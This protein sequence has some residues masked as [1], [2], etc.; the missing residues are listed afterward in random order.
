MLNEDLQKLMRL[1]VMLVLYGDDANARS[2]LPTNV[3][4]YKSKVRVMKAVAS[5]LKSQTTTN[6]MDRPELIDRFRGLCSK[7]LDV[8]VPPNIIKLL[9]LRKIV[10]C[11]V[12]LTTAI[13]NYCEL[14]IDIEGKANRPL[15][16]TIIAAQGLTVINFLHIYGILRIE[17]RPSTATDYLIRPLGQNR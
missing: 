3:L 4:T 15:E 10:V 13:T 9:E 17:Q 14:F 2:S 12:M 1:L 16:V 6:L 11:P 7:L 5:H 8:K